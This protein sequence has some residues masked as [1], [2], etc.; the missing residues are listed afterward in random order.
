MLISYFINT[1]SDTDCLQ[2]E[3]ARE[4][5]DDW[6]NAM[7]V[8]LAGQ[9]FSFTVFVLVP[10]FQAFQVGILS[11]KSDKYVHLTP[12]ENTRRV[13]RKGFEYYTILS[14]TSKFILGV[15]Y[16]AFVRMFPFYTLST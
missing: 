4:Q 13:M 15:T 3:E 5:N 14:C 7:I 10:I 1:S 12:E 6:S 8:V 11:W 9:C 2:S 16:I